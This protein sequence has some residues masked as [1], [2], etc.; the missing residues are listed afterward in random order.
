MG[1]FGEFVFV[2]AAFFKVLEGP[3]CYF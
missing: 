2:G 3:A 1:F